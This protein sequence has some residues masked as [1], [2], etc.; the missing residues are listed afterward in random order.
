VA[1]LTNVL[2][3]YYFAEDPNHPYA[4]QLVETL[5]K[6]REEMRAS[7]LTPVELYASREESAPSGF[8]RITPG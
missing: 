1:Y 5:R 6:R 2:L 4:A 3:S 8:R 7:L